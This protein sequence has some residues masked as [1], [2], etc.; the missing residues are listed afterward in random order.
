MFSIST[1]DAASPETKIRATRG[2]S[3]DDTD[4][5]FI[6]SNTERM[7]I[8]SSGV[9]QVKNGST[10]G[11]EIKLT[12]TDNDFTLNGQR[13][14]VVFQIAGTDAYIMDSNQLYP[15]VDNGRNLGTAFLRYSVVYSANGVNTSDKT[16]KENI[17]ECD[18]G[19]DFINSLKPKS[20]N[21]KDLKED[22]DAYGKKRYGLIAQDILQT[23]LKDSV[24]GK[25]DGEYGLSYNDLI[26]PMIKAIQ[27]LKADNDSLKARIETLENK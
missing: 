21:F 6:T 2:A 3:Y 20:Y 1:S 17:E 13:G 22:N 10:L 14:Q 26:A 4:I 18:L 25:K 16:L 27:E 11:G 12:G 24:F 15:S 19:I 5:S 7:R 9:I 23:E 8:N